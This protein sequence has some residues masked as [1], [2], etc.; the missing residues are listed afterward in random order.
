MNERQSY[1][2]LE[3]KVVELE[4][5]L[6]VIQELLDKSIDIIWKMDLRLPFT[7]VSPSVYNITGFTPEEWTG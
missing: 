2:E 3:N 7:Y 5:K 4:E 1:R 6:Q